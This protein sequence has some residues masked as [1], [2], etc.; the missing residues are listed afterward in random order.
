MNVLFGQV[1]AI[2]KLNEKMLEDW[3]TRDPEADEAKVQNKQT[4]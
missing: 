3:H 1:E 2:R 4:N